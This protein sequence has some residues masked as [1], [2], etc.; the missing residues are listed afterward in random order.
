MMIC[1]AH[2]DVHDLGHF[3]LGLYVM[4]RAQGGLRGGTLLLLT[5][6]LAA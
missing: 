6:A 1:K 2:A 3:I 5:A 4:A